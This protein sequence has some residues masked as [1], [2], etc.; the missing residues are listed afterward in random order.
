MIWEIGSVLKHL[1]LPPLGLGWLLVLAWLLVRRRP[2][3]AR[4]LMF[5][6]LCASALL[7]M[8]PVSIALTRLVEVEPR[9]QEFAGAQAIVI[10]SGGRGLRF[11]PDGNVVDGYPG[12]FTLHRIHAGARIAR[13]TGLP[14][15]VSSGKPDG[16]DPTEAEVMRRVLEADLGLRV[17]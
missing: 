1:V 14:I 6:F 4:W 10:L 11:G 16:F 2:G 7:S 15:L 3:A 5:G 17:R 8:T 13:S 9:P 12:L